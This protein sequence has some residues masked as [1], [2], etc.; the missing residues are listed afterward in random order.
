MHKSRRCIEV[1][2]SPGRELHKKFLLS[3]VKLVSLIKHALGIRRRRRGFRQI[4]RRR[5]C[6][7]SLVFAEPAVYVRR[8]TCLNS[9]FLVTFP[10]ATEL[11]FFHFSLLIASR[12]IAHKTAIYIISQRE[13]TGA[14]W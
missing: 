3:I 13:T 12:V 2:S 8:C 9:L 5:A 6:S 7:K 14:E 4:P 11:I 10:L 1:R